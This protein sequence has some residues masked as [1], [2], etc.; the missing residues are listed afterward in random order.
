MRRG[1]R[2]ILRCLLAY[3]TCSVNGQ[4]HD[5]W[6]HEPKPAPAAHG[7]N[8]NNAEWSQVC[9]RSTP[10]TWNGMEWDATTACSQLHEL[11]AE[12]KE[13]VE[14]GVTDRK[15]QERREEHRI[16]QEGEEAQKSTRGTPVGRVH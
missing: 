1:Q 8:T 2:S 15:A 14:G 7:A 13:A 3:Q 9:M 16:A 11:N 5:S 10:T 6:L 4:L 12:R